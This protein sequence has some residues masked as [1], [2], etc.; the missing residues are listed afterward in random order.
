[1]L[2]WAAGVSALAQDALVGSWLAQTG[3]TSMRIEFR[4]DGTYSRSCH[5]GHHMWADSGTYRAADG[6]I[7]LRVCG[8]DHVIRL[9]Y[10]MPDANRLILTDAAGNSFDLVRQ[11][12]APRSG[13]NPLPNPAPQAAFPQPMATF[14]QIVQTLQVRYGVAWERERVRT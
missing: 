6:A 11:K 12:V 5:D 8:R 14:R 13:S 9:R 7:D 3:Q 10:Q 4:A 1:M 2:F